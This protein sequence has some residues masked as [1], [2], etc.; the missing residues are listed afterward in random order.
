[1][2]VSSL[3][4]FSHGLFSRKEN[5]GGEKHEIHRG[6]KEDSQ[7]RTTNGVN[8]ANFRLEIQANIQCVI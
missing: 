7:A 6:K 1:M 5:G 4:I 2:T 8:F 3:A